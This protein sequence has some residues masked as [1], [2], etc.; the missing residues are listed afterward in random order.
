MIVLGDSHT[1]AYG[2]S[3]KF[4]PIF[5]GSGKEINFIDWN[6]VDSLINKCSKLEKYLH[7]ES[8]IFCMG[9]PD[10][11]YAMGLGWHP[12]LSSRARDKD[13]YAFL[14]KCINRYLIFIKEISESLGWSVFVQNVVLTQ[15]PI[16]CAYIDFYN[17]KLSDLIGDN[18][19]AFNDKIRAPDGVIDS[20]FSWDMI[21]ANNRICSFVESHF[22]FENFSNDLISN[23]SMKKLLTKSSRFN[24]FEF[25]ERKDKKTF[26]RRFLNAVKGFANGR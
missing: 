13:N 25:K 2:L 3:P 4:T 16:Q 19:I 6:N 22:K 15:D 23:D 8:V 24:G 9:E 26:H 21:H 5:L 17:Q 20:N 1:R 12:W 10:T 11:R 7:P 18:F 14:E